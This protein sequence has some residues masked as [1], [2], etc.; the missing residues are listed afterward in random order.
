MKADDEE[1]KACQ[2]KM[3]VAIK[4]GQENMEAAIHTIRL[5]LYDYQISGGKRRSV[6]RPK[7]TAP[8]G[9]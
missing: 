3:E 6:C 2:G 1:M 8:Q 5:E 4:S 7:N 9:T